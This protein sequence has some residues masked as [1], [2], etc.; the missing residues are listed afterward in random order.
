MNKQNYLAIETTPETA[1]LIEQST[2]NP[3]C[4]WKIKISSAVLA[5]KG[6][7]IESQRGVGELWHCLLAMTIGDYTD[8]RML[9][10]E[11]VP[12]LAPHTFHIIID[13]RILT[14]SQK[15]VEKF[16]RGFRTSISLLTKVW[17]IITI[18]GLVPRRSPHLT[19]NIPLATA[20]LQ[21]DWQ[22][23][24]ELIEQGADIKQSVTQLNC[25]QMAQAIAGNPVFMQYIHRKGLTKDFFI[26]AMHKEEIQSERESFWRVCAQPLTLKLF[27][28]FVAFTPAE[29]KQLVLFALDYQ[30][31]PLLREAINQGASPN[32]LTPEDNEPLAEAVSGGNAD[33]VR[34]LLDKGA[35]V[36]D[37]VLQD[38]PNLKILQ[39][40]LDYGADKNRAMANVA[41]ITYWEYLLKQGAELEQ[42]VYF[43][44]AKNIKWLRAHGK[45]LNKGHLF[46]S[47]QGEFPLI[48]TVGEFPLVEEACALLQGGADPNQ[49]DS[50]QETA[51]DYACRLGWHAGIPQKEISALVYELLKYGAQVHPQNLLD[52]VI[53]WPGEDTALL[54]KMIKRGADMNIQDEDGKTPLLWS[55]ERNKLETAYLLLRYGANPN[56]ANKYGW[57]PLASAEMLEN[58]ELIDLLQ[59]YG[60][61]K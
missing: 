40:L 44:E 34:Y 23:A 20:I 4:G 28:P 59:N 56:Q 45:D 57:T 48:E 42:I 5:E 50:E 15:E 47:P 35:K 7:L 11:P 36:T 55:I 21:K 6:F 12:S 16:C 29:L 3:L 24:Q 8:A 30:D 27:A 41:D 33:I 32:P 17:K 46:P 9:Y 61:I 52:A 49:Q 18:F 37:D 2:G 43:G 60:V 39:C 1:F 58:K 22:K 25:Y 26:D 51:L 19:K 10:H 14:D 54:E 31:L 53:Y 13:K 38:I